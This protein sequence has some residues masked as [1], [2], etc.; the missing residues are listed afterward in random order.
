MNKKPVIL[1]GNGGHAAVLLEILQI[2]QREILG[3]TAPEQ[4]EN[5][6]NLPYLGSDEI[7]KEYRTDEI[8]IAL[9][10]GT[11]EISAIRKNIFEE[12]KSLG[13]KFATII[14]PKVI[15]SSTVTLGEGVQI[16]AGTIVQ[17]QTEIADNTIINTGTIID[18]DCKIDAHTHIAPGVT[19]SGGVHIGTCCHVGT[20]A[21]IIQG[22][23]IGEKSLIGAG[24]VVVANIAEEKRAF[25]VPA[26]EV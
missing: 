3:F 24:A 5:A 13:Y 15:I 19:I 21:T 16:M 20:A 17:A 23:T 14:H 11:I 9:G 10:L 4:Q 12:F 25:G 6:Y 7:I 1:L 8:E 26:K 22:V 18:H 2:Q